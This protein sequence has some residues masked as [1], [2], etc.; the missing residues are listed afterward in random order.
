MLRRYWRVGCKAA[1]IAVLVLI[2]FQMVACGT[3]LYPER[4]G[5]SAGRIDPAIAILDGVG[6]LLFIIPGVV[7]FGVDFATGAIYLPSGRRKKSSIGDGPT[8]VRLGRDRLSLEDIASVV[9]DGTGARVDFHS[10]SLRV[11]EVSGGDTDILKGMLS[12]L[13]PEAGAPARVDWMAAR[14][15]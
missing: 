9:R 3:I 6:L 5:Q 4:R 2:V 1:R 7:A 8:V 10:P 13:S 14:A 15:G 11:C 12:S